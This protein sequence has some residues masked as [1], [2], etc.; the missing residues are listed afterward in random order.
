MVT[1]RRA[2]NAGEQ[3]RCCCAKQGAVLLS[4]LVMLLTINMIGATLTSLF[5]SV[6]TTADLEHQRAQALYLAEA[7]L[8]LALYQLKQ[9]GQG[10]AA[11]QLDVPPTPLGGGTYAVE[12]DVV[13]GIITATGEFQEVRR[14]IQLKYHVF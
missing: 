4:T 5:L 2:S 12:H 11:V 3:P 8:T 1:V 10:S 13:S 14:T 6:T 7:G 9:A